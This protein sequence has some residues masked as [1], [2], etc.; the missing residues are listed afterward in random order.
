LEDL[1]CAANDAK[2]MAK[3]L[4]EY[5]AD[6]HTAIECDFAQLMKKYNKFLNAVQEG[7]MVILFFACHGCQ[8]K[9]QQRM[10]C[11]AL[12]HQQRTELEDDAP[13][14]KIQNRSLALDKVII[15]LEKKKT[16]M[17]LFLLDCCRTFKYKNTTRSDGENVKPGDVQKFNFDPGEGTCIS[18]ATQPNNCSKEPVKPKKDCHGYYTEALLECIQEPNI[19]VDLMLRKVGKKSGRN[20]KRHAKTVSQLLHQRLPRL[21]V[22]QIM[23]AAIFFIVRNHLVSL[24]L[25]TVFIVTFYT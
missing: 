5:G 3:L 25:S 7:D 8:Y 12:T 9:N 18:F 13:E 6:V 11:R 23:K 4:E 21:L 14:P 15:A 22:P 1:P 17:N 24:F 2:A 19:D 20:I 10:F 16:K